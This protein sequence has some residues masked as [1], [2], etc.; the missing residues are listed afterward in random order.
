MWIIDTTCKT[1]QV[2][3]SDKASEFCSGD[4]QLDSTHIST[5]LNPIVMIFLSRLRQM[6]VSYFELVYDR[7]YPY[8][9]IH[10]SLLATH[11][12]SELLKTLQINK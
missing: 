6:P 9:L 7:F 10:Y 2:S 8:H 11:S 1:K 3:S 5:P 4:T 12:K